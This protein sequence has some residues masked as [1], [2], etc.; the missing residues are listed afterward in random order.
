MYALF[1]ALVVVVLLWNGLPEFARVI[2]V[3]LL[4]A[5]AVWTALDGQEPLLEDVPRAARTHPF[6]P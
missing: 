6:F 2:L 3:L 1:I 4:A 5:L